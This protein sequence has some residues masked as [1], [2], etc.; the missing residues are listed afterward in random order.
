MQ[1]TKRSMMNWFKILQLYTSIHYHSNF[2]SK[3]CIA[4]WQSL[5]HQL[6]RFDLLHKNIDSHR[7]GSTWMQ[8]TK[9]LVYFSLLV[10]QS[11][12]PR[13]QACSTG[14][15]AVSSGVGCPQQAYGNIRKGYRH[16]LLAYVIGILAFPADVRLWME[17]LFCG[18]RWVW[19]QKFP[20]KVRTV[21]Y[22]A[23]LML[24]RGI[25]AK[26]FKNFF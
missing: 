20:V 17:T 26:K 11:M 15:S 4:T 7:Y 2:S 19:A 22:M 8:E 16:T 9:I 12:E 21:S 13:H 24:C 6:H 3:K 1:E 25:R 10:M 18:Y 14:R 5:E 23:Q